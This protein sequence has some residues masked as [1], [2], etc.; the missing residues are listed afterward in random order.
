MIR[1]PAQR[2][3]QLQATKELYNTLSGSPKPATNPVASG[4]VVNGPIVSVVGKHEPKA[5]T[6]GQM[7]MEDEVLE[8][9]ETLEQ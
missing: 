8:H 4:P 5:K 2:A 3:S 7:L 1:T 9:R 6:T